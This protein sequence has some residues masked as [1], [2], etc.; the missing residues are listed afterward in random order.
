VPAPHSALVL[1]VIGGGLPLRDVCIRFTQNF[2]VDLADARLCQT[3]DEL[4]LL[5]DADTY[6]K[7]K[8][9]RYM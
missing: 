1:S 9:I 7:T 3:V 8:G 4:D 2:L 5:G 6:D